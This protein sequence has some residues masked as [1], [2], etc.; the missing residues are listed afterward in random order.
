MSTVT[1]LNRLKKATTIGVVLAFFLAGGCSSLR[2]TLNITSI[3]EDGNVVGNQDANL[4]AQQLLRKGMEAYNLG[5]YYKASESF[6]EILNRYPFSKEAALA[7]LKA[8]DC[9]YFLEQYKE[10]LA[11][12]EAFENSHPTNA[13]IP[14]VMFQK[15]MCNY[16]QIDR[17]DRDTQSAEKTVQLF[18]QLLR[19]YPDS[20]YTQEAQKRIRLANDFLADHEFFVAQYYL[21]KKSYPQAETRLRYL[22]NA[23]PKASTVPEA[24]K[25]LKR[26]EAGDPPSSALTSWLPQVH[27]PNRNSGNK[28]EEE[29]SSAP[30]VER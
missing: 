15:G 4:P 3:D 26:L 11:L 25:L 28:D 30:P 5:K 29:N 22:L 27:L 24:Q 13:G 7:E 21:R 19:A 14:Y 2:D 20:P 18:K 8:A 6:E 9:Y 17:I 12:Y 16:Q 23:Y 10:A 1:A